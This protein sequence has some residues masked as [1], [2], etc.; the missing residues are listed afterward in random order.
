VTM[1]EMMRS[2]IYHKAKDQTLMRLVWL[3]S[4]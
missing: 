4:G 3:K 2:I 1:I